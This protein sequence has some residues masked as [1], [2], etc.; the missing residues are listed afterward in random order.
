MDKD[1]NLDK[2]FSLIFE[3]LIF[4]WSISTAEVLPLFLPHVTLPK[5]IG[6]QY[7]PL[8]NE[9]A[10]ALLPLSHYATQYRLSKVAFFSFH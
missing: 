3:D 8:V 1:K 7:G 4:S 9:E 10:A 2:S 5:Q 6:M